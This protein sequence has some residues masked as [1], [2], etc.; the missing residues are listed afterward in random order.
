MQTCVKLHFFRFTT[1]FLYTC[2]RICVCVSTLIYFFLTLFST[3]F[4]MRVYFFGFG[5]ILDDINSRSKTFFYFFFFLFHSLSAFLFSFPFFWPR[6][7]L[8]LLCA[9]Y[10]KCFLKPLLRGL[11]FLHLFLKILCLWTVLGQ[12]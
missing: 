1:L 12:L 2:A 5:S 10:S 9:F 11:H 7:N 8:L 4:W 6:A 3:R